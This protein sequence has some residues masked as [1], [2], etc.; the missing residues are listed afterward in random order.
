MAA[1]SLRAR[2]TLACASVACMLTLALAPATSL[3]TALPIRLIDQ[4][5]FP[6]TSASIAILHLNVLGTP[7]LQA[8]ALGNLGVWT[9]DVSITMQC[10]DIADT[11]VPLALLIPSS[12]HA[13]VDG[14]RISTQRT[15]I[16]Q[17]PA[18]PDHVWDSA[19]ITT[20]D[21]TPG[22]VFVLRTRH[23]AESRLDSYGQRF[24]DLPVHGL[25][26]FVDSISTATIH[27]ELPD[28]PVA[29]QT[30]L[31]N[32]VFYDEPDPA[33]HWYVQAWEPTINL[34]T[35]WVSP[36]S[37]LQMVAEIESCPPPWQ[38]IQ[39]LT[40]SQSADF[41]TMAGTFDDSTLRFC[42]RLPEIIHGAPFDNG[43]VLEQL[44][45]IMMSRYLPNLAYDVPLYRPN[46]GWALSHLSEVEAL[47]RSALQSV[48]R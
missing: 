23:S 4:A 8:E 10:R 34:Q 29:L 7:S 44:S 3:A 41:N 9:W 45:S 17:D 46:R 6:S 12:G 36:W 21:C 38:V 13:W 1:R 14:D 43:P 16:R 28:R 48:S 39:Q 37:A 47:Y 35:S 15:A 27:I 30:S 2:L 26:L 42:A 24:L 33:L 19:Q 32:P 20:I 31:G 40:N 11:D 5:V 18:L 25:G 22:R